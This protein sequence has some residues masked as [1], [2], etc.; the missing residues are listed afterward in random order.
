MAAQLY[1]NIYATSSER[2]KGSYKYPVWDALVE[3]VSTQVISKRNTWIL[4]WINLHILCHVESIF[5]SESKKKE[6]E[7]C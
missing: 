5:V 2:L 1:G 6:T 3:Q 7:K 4:K